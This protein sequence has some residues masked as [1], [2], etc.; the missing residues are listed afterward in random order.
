MI[1]SYFKE[2]IS[3]ASIMNWT[4]AFFWSEMHFYQCMTVQSSRYVGHYH[5]RMFN[6]V[7]ATVVSAIAIPKFFFGT[8]ELYAF[9]ISKRIYMLLII[10]A[11]ILDINKCLHAHLLTSI[12]VDLL[13][14]TMQVLDG[15]SCCMDIS[16]LQVLENKDNNWCSGEVPQDST[17]DWDRKSVV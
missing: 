16:S 11:K 9:Y 15:T 5:T 10:V 8:W 17:N 3:G 6:L 12:S 13:D 4:H 7:V 14:S 2:Q 1:C